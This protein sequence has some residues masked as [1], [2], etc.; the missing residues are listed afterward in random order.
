MPVRVVVAGYYGFGNVGDEAVLAATLP[1]LRERIPGVDIT[2]LSGDPVQ[3]ARLHAVRAVSRS[4]AARVLTG[5]DLFLFGGGSLLQDVTSARSALYYLGLLG[6]ATLLARRTMIFAQGIGPLRRRWLRRAAAALL[7]RVDVVTVRDDDARAAAQDLGVHRPVHVVADPVFAMP[8]G[9][10][11]AMHDLRRSLRPPHLGLALRPWADNRYLDAVIAAVGAVRDETGCTVVALPFH[12]TRDLEVCAIAAKALGGKVVAGL[13][14]AEM[15]AVVGGLDL[16]VGVRL[17][18]LIGAVLTGVAPVG[19]SYDPKI[20]GLFRRVGMGQLLSLSA[21]GAGPLRQAI[22]RAWEERLALRARLLA[23][24][25]ALR[26][27]ALRAIDLAAALL[28]TTARA[29]RT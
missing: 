22:V 12:A 16:L 4:A 26:E 24:A 25:A 20:D 11:A 27:D 1:A 8:G 15:L 23:R 21:L 18:A 14:P 28:S 5:A 10:G 2:V 17:H 13:A 6:I 19:L 29:S 7:N 9:T 3:T